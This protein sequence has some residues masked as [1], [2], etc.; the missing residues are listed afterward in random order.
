M[1]TLH[2]SVAGLPLPQETRAMLPLLALPES[3]APAPPTPTPDTP[4]SVVESTAVEVDGDSFHNATVSVAEIAIAEFCFFVKFG[5]DSNFEDWDDDPVLNEFVKVA[6]MIKQA[7]VRFV[8]KQRSSTTAV[9]AHSDLQRW[10]RLKTLL[11]TI[12]SSYGPNQENAPTAT[13]FLDSYL[14][15]RG[16][17]VDTSPVNRSNTNGWIGRAEIYQEYFI[18]SPYSTS[19]T[20]T[21]TCRVNNGASGVVGVVMLNDR[22]AV[23]KW[24]GFLGT[25]AYSEKQWLMQGIVACPFYTA[26]GGKGVA[27]AL[28]A[29][30]GERLRRDPEVSHVAVNVAS[31]APDFW[32]EKLAST[33]FVNCSGCKVR[34]RR[35]A[36]ASSGLQ[37]GQQL[38]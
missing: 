5:L 23:Y 38:R 27:S 12:L 17:P 32:K 11:E 24:S 3:I 16:L 7:A 6:E 21:K 18:R 20:F 26:A 34:K 9:D 1:T 13:A 10:A 28:L 4:L 33:D 14:E 2:N 15:E 19:D 31:Y 30:V 36:S 22:P 25:E 29:H 37:L 35:K 8:N